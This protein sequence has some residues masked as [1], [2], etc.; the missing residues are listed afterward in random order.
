MTSVSSATAST[1]TQTTETSKSSTDNTVLSSD[2]ETFL[3][4]LTTQLENQDPLNP[5]E[6]TEFATQ[7]ATFSGVEQQVR[8]N[9]LLESLNEAF[10]GAGLGQYGGWVGM[11]GRAA[12][13]A[14]YSGSPITVFPEIDPDANTAKLVVLDEN[15]KEIFSTSI[16]ID[17]DPFEWDGTDADGN[18][19]ETG[20]YSFVV[21]SYDKGRQISEAQAEV[22][23]PIS[24]VRSD[25]D[26]VK[27]VFSGDEEVS[28]ADVTA[29]R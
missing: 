28:P 20:A 14:N 23:M 3:K 4:M 26:G 19:V 9:T 12:V 7:I 29:L 11:E 10:G 8:T 5:M 13:S 15:K 22:Y 25:S 17:G 2:F 18:V 21:R 16:G 1:T 24:E 27:I 6:S